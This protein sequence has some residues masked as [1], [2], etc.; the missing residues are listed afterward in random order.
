MAITFAVTVCTEHEELKR[1]LEIL[2][3]EYQP[4]DQL[5]VQWDQL[6]VSDE[7]RAVLED[8]KPDVDKYVRYQA[9]L[10]NDFATFKNTIFEHATGD[11][12]FQL[13]ADEYPSVELIRNLRPILEENKDTD[14]L[15]VPRV[16]L[17]EGITLKHVKEWGWNVQKIDDPIFR[18][19]IDGDDLPLETLELLQKYSLIDG[20]VQSS[21]PG[22]SMVTKY[23]YHEPVINYPDYQWR[24]YQNKP[25]IRWVNRVH[26]RLNGF[27]TYAALPSMLEYSL[28]HPKTIRKQE[29]QNDKYSKIQG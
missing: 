3:G 20:V 23:F 10:Y 7:V 19:E 18:R 5:L 11:W 1:L 28:F 4:G 29:M 25:Y 13:D 15:L 17:V 21:G 8:H 6:L 24:L 27:N 14:V 26:E 16:N 2:D 12:I 9:M 22:G